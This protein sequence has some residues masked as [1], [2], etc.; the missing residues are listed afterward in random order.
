MIGQWLKE[1]KS[2]GDKVGTRCGLIH[3]VGEFHLRKMVVFQ[4]V[5][6]ICCDM[7]GRMIVQ[8]VFKTVQ[9][10]MAEFD[11]VHHRHGHKENPQ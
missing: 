11:Q 6:L 1:S 10:T 2:N 3:L 8:R 5:T 4:R 7:A 9:Y